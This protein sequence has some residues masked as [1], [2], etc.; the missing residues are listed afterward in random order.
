MQAKGHDVVGL[1]LEGDNDIIHSVDITDI[2]AVSKALVKIKPETIIHLAAISFV[3]FKDPG[4]L[5]DINV[6]GSLN[7][8]TSALQLE[9]TAENSLCQFIPG[10]WK[11]SGFN[12]AY[13]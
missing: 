4:K 8:F 12:A 6:N 7:I 3:N 2:D 11:C 1:D 13:F 9:K 10:L 5:Y